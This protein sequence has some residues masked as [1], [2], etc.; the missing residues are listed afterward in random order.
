MKLPHNKPSNLRRFNQMKNM[1]YSM[2]SIN[3]VSLFIDMEESRE[4]NGSP[5]LKI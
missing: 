2:D 3:D 4:S 5:Q 1:K